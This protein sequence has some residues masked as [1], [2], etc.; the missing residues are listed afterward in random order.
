MKLHWVRP[1]D[2]HVTA[3]GKDSQASVRPLTYLHA[4][5]ADCYAV[6]GKVH[7]MERCRKCERINETELPR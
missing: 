4:E 1:N 2:V 6:M 7:Q 5:A 3:C